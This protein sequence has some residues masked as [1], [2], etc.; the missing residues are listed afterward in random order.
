MTLKVDKN[1]KVFILSPMSPI[2]GGVELL[3]QL[4][5]NLR[6]FM[7]I[8][9]Y[10]Y[11]YPTSPKVKQKENSY[12]IPPVETIP[13]EYYNILIIPEVFTHLDI[14]KNLK[15][16]RKV[17]WWLSVD[18]Y[19][20]EYLSS[21]KFCFLQRGINKIYR[22]FFKSEIYNIPILLQNRINKLNNM[23]KNNILV[24]EAY[25][26]L[27][28]S[29]YAENYLLKSGIREDIIYY[30]SDYI[31]E[32][33]L[34]KPFSIKEKENIV[35]YNYR[36]G[37]SFT[38]HIINSAPDIKFIPLLNM[39]RFQVIEVLRRAKVY[40]DFGNHPGKDR[41]PREAAISGCCVITGKRGSAAFFEDVPI[42]DGYKFDD[43]KENIPKIVEKIKDCLENY[44]ERYKDFANYR[45]I[46]KK[47]PE[48]FIKDMKKIFI[49]SGKNGK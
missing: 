21:K 44:N 27:V 28:Q 7:G 42:P 45:E 12:N 40:I 9:T 26:H 24:R 23:I 16:I 22:I 34:A 13:D 4:G 38:K 20:W 25:I 33:F 32:D 2:I 15:S 6:K 1:T 3:H 43:R 18:N 17:M 41:P 10:M 39:T 19:F 48:K 47:E 29:A 37:Y 5:Y 8:E 35:V 49:I 11:Y 46:I 30:L 14:L 31:N 36:K